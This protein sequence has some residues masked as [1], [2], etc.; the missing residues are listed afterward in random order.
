MVNAT[1]AYD[2]DVGRF[3]AQA[4]VRAN[5]LF[6]ELALNHASFLTNSAPLRGRNFVV[7]LRTVF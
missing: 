3:G 5:N 2:F 6:D 7:G 1:V 4:Y